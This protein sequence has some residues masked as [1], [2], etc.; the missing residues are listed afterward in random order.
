MV[1][2]IQESIKKMGSG[3]DREANKAVNTD[4]FFARCAHH[5][6][7]GYGRRWAAE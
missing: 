3:M 7:A 5:K 2:H 4:V 1:L 6:Y